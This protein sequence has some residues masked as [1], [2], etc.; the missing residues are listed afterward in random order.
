M[1]QIVAHTLP[2]FCQRYAIGRTKAYA[3]IKAGRLKARKNGRITV[4]TEADAQEWLANLPHLDT[5]A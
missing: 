5:A 4:I 3:E 2:N 1:S